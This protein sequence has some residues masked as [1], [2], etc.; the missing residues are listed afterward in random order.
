LDEAARKFGFDPQPA[1]LMGMSM[2]GSVAVHA[3]DMPDAPW[4]ALVV[5]ASFDS[6]PGVIKS[7]AVRY[8]G[9]TLGP[10]W[11]EATGS[12]YQ[13]KSGTRLRSVFPP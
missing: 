9:M 7:Q 13:W 12:V 8:S 5:V 1:G 3:A 11:A 4:K 2:G 6:F 10:L